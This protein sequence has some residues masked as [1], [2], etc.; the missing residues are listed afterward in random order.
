MKGPTVEPHTE[1]NHRQWLDL[2]DRALAVAA[3]GITIADARQPGRPLIYVNEGFER[4][5]GYS[6]AE[7][8][9]RNCKFLQGRGSDPEVVDQIRTAL[10]AEQ[11]CTV[12]ILNYRKDG[13]PFWN[14]LSITPV[15]DGDNQLTHFIGIQSDVTQRR[16]AEEALRQAKEELERANTSMQRDLVE[17]AEIQRAW[18][19]QSLPQVPGYRFA[20]SFT[21]CQELGGDSLNV[22]QLD[23][24]HVGI[25]VL[26]VCGHGVGAALLSASIQRWLSPVPENSC[27]FVPVTGANGEFAIASPA[28]VANDLN[29][30]FR[31]EPESGKFFTLIY[32]V[33]DLRNGEFRYATAGHAPPLRLGKDG[34]EACAPAFGLPIGVLEDFEFGEVQI[35]LRPGD[36]LLLYTDGASEAT[37]TSDRL[38]GTERLLRDLEQQRRQSPDKALSALMSRLR[39]WGGS[40]TLEDDVTLLM[41]DVTSG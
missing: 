4:L 40:D 28:A 18:L 14:R 22:L 34:A 39:G 38:Y 12:E 5:T 24:D 26:D 9:G 23:R 17:A 15:R 19:P 20:W 3:E 21:P 41:V 10:E 6:T 11:E 36:R 8:L 31:A 33:L 27:L 30:R 32:G 37:D 16:L 35:Q 25:Y 2:K 29:R 7:V 13:T 1:I